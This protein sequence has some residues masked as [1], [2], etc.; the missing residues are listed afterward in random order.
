M[1]Y[2]NFYFKRKN[3]DFHFWFLFSVIYVHTKYMT[4]LPFLFQKRNLKM[5]RLKT[6]HLE[7]HQ[8]LTPM[9]TDEDTVQMLP[10]NYGLEQI[11]KHWKNTH[12]I[13]LPYCPT[14][15]GVSKVSGASERVSAAEGVSEASIPEQANEW[16]VRANERTDE[17][18]AQYSNLF[19]WLFWPTCTVKLRSSRLWTRNAIWDATDLFLHLL[20]DEVLPLVGARRFDVT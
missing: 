20:F 9:P 12:L 19:S 1:T 4:S 13:I 7:K 8:N 5:P 6:C 3:S 15:E 10:V 14:R 11:K 17:W 2:S 16:A 18:V